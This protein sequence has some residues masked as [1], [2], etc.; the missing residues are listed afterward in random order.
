MRS[1]GLGGNPDAGVTDGQLSS[2]LETALQV[3]RKGSGALPLQRGRCLTFPP[4]NTS[5][6]ATPR[7]CGSDGSRLRYKGEPTRSVC[8]L[9]GTQCSV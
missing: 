8:F 6:R 4:A 3:L 7:L 5:N 1:C 2:D 9:V